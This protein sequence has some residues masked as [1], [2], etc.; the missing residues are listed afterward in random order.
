MIIVNFTAA[1]GMMLFENNDPAHFGTLI[2]AMM[3]IWQIETLDSWEE[4]LYINMLG[5]AEYAYDMKLP[6]DESHEGFTES[7]ERKFKI[8]PGSRSTG[9]AMLQLNQGD[10]MGRSSVLR[11]C[12]HARRDGASDA[13]DRRN[14]PLVR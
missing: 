4:I 10:G 11:V 1:L 3:S 14:F 8:W 2:R 9:W 6:S 7:K 12:H 5:C 13:L